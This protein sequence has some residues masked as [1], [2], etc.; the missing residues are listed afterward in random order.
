M[1]AASPRIGVTGAARGGFT[2][3]LFRSGLALVF[4]GLRVSV[5]RPRRALRGRGYGT[6][7]PWPPAVVDGEVGRP[8]L[9]VCMGAK[10]RTG[11]HHGSRA[12]LPPI[13]YS[14]AGSGGAKDDRKRSLLPGFAAGM[15]GAGDGGTA[16]AL[17]H[18][19]LATLRLGTRRPPPPISPRKATRSRKTGWRGAR[20]EVGPRR[21]S[22]GFEAL[23]DDA[24]GRTFRLPRCT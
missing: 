1:L 5:R 23:G 10:A 7:R 15:R 11:R 21:R 4:S 16:T 14:A 6:R 17:A 12:R 19:E 24:R 3:N 18:R 20:S 9:H 2:W 8:S 22:T 13:A